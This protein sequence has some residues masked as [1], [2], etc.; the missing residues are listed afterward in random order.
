MYL[1]Q[2]ADIN[3]YVTLVRHSY[4]PIQWVFSVDSLLRCAHGVALGSFVFV[5]LCLTIS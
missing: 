5:L 3:T 2:D 4:M 1:M